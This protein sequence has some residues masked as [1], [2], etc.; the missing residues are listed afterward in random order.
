MWQH[1]Q[2]AVMVR[3]MVRARIPAV[4]QILSKQSVEQERQQMEQ[5]QL[6]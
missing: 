5:W 2:L 1:V 4:M 6:R 3:A